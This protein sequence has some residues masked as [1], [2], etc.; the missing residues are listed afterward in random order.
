MNPES[1]S[2]A[3]KESSTKNCVLSGLV[4]F[5]LSNGLVILVLGSLSQNPVSCIAGGVTCSTASVLHWYVCQKKQAERGEPVEMTS[6][7]ASRR[8]A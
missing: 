2:K 7:L 4:T 5:L 6:H 1:N 8:I 3:A